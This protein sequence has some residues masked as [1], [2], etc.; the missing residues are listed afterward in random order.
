MNALNFGRRLPARMLA[1]EPRF[2]F[3]AAAVT[4]LAEAD[5]EKRAGDRANDGE[6]PSDDGSDA[7]S[8]AEAA[9][10][11]PSDR[12]AG[13]VEVVVVDPTVENAGAIVAGLP[14]GIEVL[15]LERNDEGVAAIADALAGRH[16]IDALHIISHGEAGR[17]MLGQTEVTAGTVA[18]DRAQWGAIGAAFAPEGDLL[19]YGCDVG[20]GD[21]GA[22]LLAG[23]AEATGTDVAASTNATGAAAAGG[24]WELEVTDG[25]IDTDTLA[26]EDFDH[27]LAA[28]PAPGGGGA[29]NV[30]VTLAA[31]TADA[32]ICQALTNAFTQANDSGDSVT[33]NG[34]SG[35]QFALSGT[36]DVADGVKIVGSGIDN[37]TITSGTGT[38]GALR[39][40]GDSATWEVAGVRNALGLNLTASDPDG[41][42]IKTGTGELELDGNANDLPGGITVSGGGL[43]VNGSLTNA[44]GAVALASGTTLRG[45]GTIAGPVTVAAGAT[46]APGTSPG[47]LTVGGLS[48]ATNSTAAIE[49]RTATAGS[50]YDRTV[51]NG[52]VSLGGATLTLDA[53]GLV[54]D[55]GTVFTIIVND[56][57]DAIVGT[58]A[59]LA[60]GAEVESGEFRFAISYTGGDGNDVTLTLLDTGTDPGTDPETTEVDLPA[61]ATDAEIEQALSDALTAA[62]QAGDVVRLTGA[63]ESAFEIASTMDVADGVEIDGSAIDDLVI[64]SGTATP[65]IIRLTGASAIW[66]VDGSDVENFLAIDFTATDPSGRLIKAG[67]GALLLHGIETDLP[68]GVSVEEGSLVVNGR[69]INADGAV[70]LGSGTS[71]R[72]DGVIAGVVTATGATVAPGNSPGILTVGGLTLDADSTLAIELWHPTPGVGYDQVAVNGAVDL[73]G[74]TLSVDATGFEGNDGESYVIVANDGQDAIVGTFAGLAEGAV[75]E[76]AGFQYTISYSGGDGNDVSLTLVSGGTGVTGSAPT[77]ESAGAAGGSGGGPPAGLAAPAGAQQRQGDER[78]DPEGRDGRDGR[79]GGR[80]D[81]GPAAS[82][83][84]TEAAPPPLSHGPGLGVGGRAAPLSLAP[85]PPPPPPPPLPSV[86]TGGGGDSG[87]DSAGWG[88]EDVADGSTV[89]GGRGTAAAASAFTAFALETADAGS[90]ALSWFSAYAFG[91]ALAAGGSGTST[92][93]AGLLASEDA[94]LQAVGRMLSQ[95]AAGAEIPPDQ[96]RLALRAFGV[97][98]SEMGLLMQSYYAARKGWLSSLVAPAL[99]EISQGHLTDPFADVAAA[100]AAVADKLPALTGDRVAL[101]IGVQEYAHGIPALATPVNDVNGIGRVLERSYGYQ[102][103]VISNGSQAQVVGALAALAQRLGPDHSLIVYFA[104]H[105]YQMESTGTAY[106]LPADAAA[107]SAERWISTAD[108]SRFLGRVPAGDI[109][110]VSDSCYSGA[111]VGETGMSAGDRQ[112]GA[113]AGAAN[114]RSVVVMSSGGEEPVRDDGTGGHSVFAGNLINSLR[115][116]GGRTGFQLYAEVR[117]K[118]SLVTYQTPEYGTLPAAGHQTGADFVLSGR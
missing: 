62:D 1:L 118:V 34:P 89:G 18:R 53:A 58:F 115:E 56:Q 94:A 116:G 60:E 16:D 55:A 68:G 108:V 15:I 64:N 85:P 41:R 23:L 43:I 99:A 24:D 7:A 101:L 105:G 81:G 79:D 30:N 33:L 106:W 19:L 107:T 110:M 91:G 69:L 35:R 95:V 77:A 76:A 112:A 57:Q 42:L 13:R 36:L 48:L 17:L 80:A 103:I 28:P 9:G 98:G 37:L 39:L 104:G 31:N 88:A 11:E 25:S 14:A 50:G 40:T 117:D 45:S 8:L 86:A 66:R 87:A 2:V 63:H 109:L 59:G 111:L 21:Q 22:A 114:G 84:R 51:V 46:L 92:A 20:R 26:V 102:S 72:G 75:I 97:S 67:S 70:T 38:A 83:G 61:D 29:T 49:L 82:Y 10:L 44:A 5:D 90:G 73:G 32:D 3:D 54:A 100:A 74:A 4:T 27:V 113:E 78:G 96:M 93:I 6:E 12:G 47:S 52:T 65:G 71:L